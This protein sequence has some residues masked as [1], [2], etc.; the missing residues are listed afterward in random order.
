MIGSTNKQTDKKMVIDNRMEIA[1]K[2]FISANLLGN[3]LLSILSWLA[4]T[5]V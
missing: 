4:W 5:R 2:R 3:P 1:M